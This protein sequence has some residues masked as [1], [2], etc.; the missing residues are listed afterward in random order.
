MKSNNNNSIHRLA[1]RLTL[2][3]GALALALVPS[4]VSAHDNLGG[5]E[6]AT[7]NWMLVGAM[8]TVVIGVFWGIWAAKTGQFSNVEESK[9]VM[10]ENAEDYDAIM[11]EFDAKEQATR[12]AVLATST[13]SKPAL[14]SADPALPRP[15]GSS[16]GVRI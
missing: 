4:A 11:A 5:D 15:A 7:A 14:T 10:L 16:P 1:A 8:V 13:A 2:V 3:T 12:D 9:Y 6:L